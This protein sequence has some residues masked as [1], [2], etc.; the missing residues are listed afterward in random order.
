MT[1]AWSAYTKHVAPEVPGCPHSIIENAI[2]DA[3]IQFCGE[4]LIWREDLTAI[5]T[6]V[7]QDEYALVLPTDTRF[8]LAVH[9]QYDGVTIDPRSEEKEDYLNDGWRNADDGVPSYYHVPKPNTIKFNVPSIAVIVG[10]IKVRAAVKPARDAA[11]GDDLLYHDWVEI[12]AHGAKARLKSMKAKDWSDARGA[13]YCDRQFNAGIQHA[14]SRARRG[15]TN[16]KS[17]VKLRRFV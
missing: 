4:S 13:V 11:G 14:K 15:H 8:V 2:R 5:D 17:R 10:G 6:V 3:A 9:V 7:S 1:T 12:L 16:A